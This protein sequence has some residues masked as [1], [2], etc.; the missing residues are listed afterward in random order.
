MAEEKSPL[1]AEMG[2]GMENMRDALRSAAP[3]ETLRVAVAMLEEEEDVEL[4]ASPS[5]G[6]FRRIFRWEGERWVR[7]IGLGLGSVGMILIPP[8]SLLRLGLGLSESKSKHI[9]DYS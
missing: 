6:S 1:A 2:V 7:D 3:G 8:C 4:E 9:R 5:A